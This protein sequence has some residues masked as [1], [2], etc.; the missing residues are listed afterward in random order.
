MRRPPAQKVEAGRGNPTLE[1]LARVAKGL[2]VELSAL[3][4]AID[5]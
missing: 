5:S 4:T 3:L 2:G 1:T